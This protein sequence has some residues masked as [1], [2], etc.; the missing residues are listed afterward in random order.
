VSR[1]AVRLAAVVKAGLQYDDVVTVNEILHSW[2]QRY[3]TCALT[4]KISA[5]PF[6][7]GS[8]MILILSS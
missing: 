4:L 1:L 2:L 3:E 8:L 7:F 6:E 5:P